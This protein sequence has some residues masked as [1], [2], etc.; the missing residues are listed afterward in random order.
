VGSPQGGQ[1]GPWINRGYTKRA[2]RITINVPLDG[3]SYGAVADYVRVVAEQIEAGHTA[4]F[5]DSDT[6]WGSYGE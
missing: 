4:G 1:G 3:D 5:V 2:M 6:H